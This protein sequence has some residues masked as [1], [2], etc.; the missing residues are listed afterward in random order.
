MVKLWLSTNALEKDHK[1]TRK[2]PQVEFR[3][4]VYEMQQHNF[5]VC[6]PSTG[7]IIAHR[8]QF[9]LKLA[10]GLTIHEAIGLTIPYVIVDCHSI[11]MAS[12]MGVAIVRCV[13]KFVIIIQSLLSW[14]THQRYTVSSMSLVRNHWLTNWYVST[15]IV[16]YPFHWIKCP[17]KRWPAIMSL[18]WRGGGWLWSVSIW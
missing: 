5:S 12:Q 4:K 16:S 7:K 8:K 13:G 9:P 6:D 18:T 14:S 11:C 2:G 15:N 17:S 10:F 3:G 1:C